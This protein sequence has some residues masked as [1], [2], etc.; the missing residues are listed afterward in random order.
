MHREYSLE[1]YTINVPSVN[2]FLRF[3]E[4]KKIPFFGHC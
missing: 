1:S 3:R 2:N 4:D